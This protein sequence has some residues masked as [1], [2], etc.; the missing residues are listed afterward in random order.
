MRD[1]DRPDKSKPDDAHALALKRWQAGYER[2]RDNIDEA[3]E[4]LEFLEGNQW[5]PRA[6]T[7][8]QNEDRPMQTFN[9]MPQFVRQITGDMRLAK[10]GIKVVPVD[11]GADRAIA[12]IRAGLIRYVENRSDAQAAYCHAADQQVAAG[13][14]HWRVIKEY[15]DD[16]TFNQELRVVA[17]EDGIS[18]IWDDDAILPNKEDARWCFVPVDMSRERFKERWPDHAVTDF[19]DNAK[20]LTRRLV[21]GG[22]RARRRIL[23]EEASDAHARA[24]CRAARSTTSPTTTPR[25]RATA[26]QGIARRG[27]REPQDLPLCDLVRRHPRRS[28]G[29]ARP[30]HSDRALPGRGNPHRPQD[31]TARHHPL[32]QG[33]AARLQLRPLDPDRDHRAAAEVAVHRHG[34]EFRAV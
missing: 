23:G 2:D 7:L 33:R 13:I 1:A 14:G 28:G 10:P 4:D 18:V 17:V 31:E 21:R 32:R 29:M 8:R 27:A 25:P 24:A 6:I 19:A 3:Y 22:F 26:Q 20:A 30:L 15:A 16:T 9:R 11:S 34:K 5:P 12:R